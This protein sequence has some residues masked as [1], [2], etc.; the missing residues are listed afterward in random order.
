MK[1]ENWRIRAIHWIAFF[2]LMVT[3]A[4]LSV[5]I[6]GVDTKHS[7]ELLNEAIAKNA[8]SVETMSRLY[9]QC[10]EELNRVELVVPVPEK[11]PDM[12]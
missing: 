4:S 3:L 12:I 9:E 5:A 10:Y 11:E 8:E 7:R 6:I 1:N 2:I